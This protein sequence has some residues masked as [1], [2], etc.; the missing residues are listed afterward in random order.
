[1]VFHIY[2]LRKTISSQNI[3][4]SEGTCGL[5][6]MYL[7]SLPVRGLHK[8][9]FFS[10]APYTCCTRNIFPGWLQANEMLLLLPLQC[11]ASRHIYSVILFYSALCHSYLCVS[12]FLVYVLRMKHTSYCFWALNLKKSFILYLILHEFH[13]VLQGYIQYTRKMGISTPIFMPLITFQMP[14]ISYMHGFSAGSEPV[15]EF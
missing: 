3:P 10:D 8:S 11:G 1:M 5:S 7:L 15:S 14:I 2:I 12:P 6:L 13:F 4:P 9:F